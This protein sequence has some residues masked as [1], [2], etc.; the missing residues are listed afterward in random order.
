MTVGTILYLT[1]FKQYTINNLW[2]K[3]FAKAIENLK[4]QGGGKLIIPPG[5]Y[6]TGTIELISNLEVVLEDGVTIIGSKNLQD[7]SVHQ[8]GHN[9]DR[10]PWHLLYGKDCHNL[11][12]SGKG[13]IN[14]SGPAFW[15]RDPSSSEHKDGGFIRAH[16]DRR[17]SPMVE[18][19]NCTGLTIQDVTLTNSPGWTL[20]LHDCTDVLV[21]GI[22]I[23]NSYWAPNSDGID[24][25]GSQKVRI[26]NCDIK[27][28][29]DGICI[30]TTGDS[31]EAKDIRIDNCRVTSYCAALKLGCVESVKDMEDIHFSNCRVEESSRII[32]VYSY[33]G[34]Q[35]QNISFTNISG[36]TR[37]P[38]IQT[39]PIHIE[40]RID[41]PSEDQPDGFYYDIETRKPFIKNVRIMNFSCETEGRV[42]V[43]GEDNLEVSGI[44]LDQISLTYPW[45][46]RADRTGTTF[47]S[48]QFPRSPSQ[49]RTA[50]S[51][52]V[53]EGLDSIRVDRVQVTWPQTHSQPLSQAGSN[54]QGKAN[55]PPTDWNFPLRFENGSWDSHPFDVKDMASASDLFWIGD[56]KDVQIAGVLGEDYDEGE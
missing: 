46:Y 48:R 15:E 53:F 8:W 51:A 10:T 9:P 7:Y 37:A 1:D 44:T 49:S 55:H 6:E 31:R 42:L 27:T 52:F 32:A 36:N 45:V 56:C 50:Q 28:G 40:A 33:R 38:L 43:V 47:K 4:N 26:Y 20:H 21:E 34:A 35:I 18:L 25:T 13:T 29:D 24:I 5:T 22:R 3:G 23:R 17:P 54:S 19:V 11:T 16:K 41:M 2:T 30:K 12:I 39:R 14:G